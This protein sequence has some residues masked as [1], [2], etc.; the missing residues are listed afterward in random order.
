MNREMKEDI[1]NQIDPT[2]VGQSFAYYVLGK[3]PIET[4]YGFMEE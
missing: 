2:K 1:I 3:L 4:L